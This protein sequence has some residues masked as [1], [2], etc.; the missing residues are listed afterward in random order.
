MPKSGI[1]KIKTERKVNV[2]MKKIF[3]IVCAV[4][5]SAFVIVAICSSAERN[6]TDITDTHSGQNTSTHTESDREV[7]YI[8]KTY[9]DKIGIFYE[10]ETEPFSVLSGV[11][12]KSLSEYD[13]NLLNTG[14]KVYSDEE[15][16]RLI[17]DYDS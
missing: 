7:L 16:R 1:L 14:I 11:M 15:L 5:A 13:Q 4:A 2:L 9:N 10:D 17:E 8:L 12:L 3:L 6:N